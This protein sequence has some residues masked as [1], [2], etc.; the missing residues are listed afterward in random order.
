V[1]IGSSAG[2]SCSFTMSG[3]TIYGDVPVNTTHTP[4]STANTA[5]NTSY[6]GTNGHAVLWRKSYYY[7]RNEDLTGVDNISTTDTLPTTSGATL[8]NWTMR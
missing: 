8:N 4:G 2:A 1:N 6:L 5:T 7:Y 3:G